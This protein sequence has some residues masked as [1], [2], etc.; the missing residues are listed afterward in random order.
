MSAVNAPTTLADKLQSTIT[1]GLASSYCYIP[2][3]HYNGSWGYNFD[4]VF[5]ASNINLNA[6]SGSTYIKDLAAAAAVAAINARTDILPYTTVKIKRFSDCQSHAAGYAM[7][8]MAAQIGEDHG[9]VV[10]VVGSEYSGPTAGSAEVLGQFEIPYCSSAASSA[11]LSNKNNYPYFFRLIQSTGL[12]EYLALLY[13]SWGVSRI[14][15][16]SQSDDLMS[17]SL[18]K[19]VQQGL[20]HH[21]I[22]VVTIVNLYTALSQQ[23]VNVAKTELQIANARY[24]YISGQ[25]DFVSK[26]YF[27]LA[28]TGMVGP[29]FVY[30]G[31]IPPTQIATS[32]VQLSPDLSSLNKNL[33]QMAHLASGFISF[34]G[35]TQTPKTPWL[36]VFYDNVIALGKFD[37]KTKAANSGLH[38]PFSLLYGYWGIG[39]NF[40]CTMM[41]LLGLDELLKRNPQLS[42]GQLSSRGLSQYLNYTQFLDLG[43]NGL[44]SDPISI[45]SQG[46]LRL[47]YRASYYDGTVKSGSSAL[48]QIAFAE[49][50][51]YAS[52]ITFVKNVSA[53]FFGGSTVPPPDGPPIDIIT[54]FSNNVHSSN[55]QGI[56]VMTISGLAF[57]VCLLAFFIKFRNEK[58]V[59]IA[60]VP[61]C[62][63]LAFGSVLVYVSLPFYL[64]TVTG[65]KCAARVWLALMGYMCMMM[66][67]L[68]KNVRLWIILKSKTRV[69]ANLLTWVNRGVI[70]VGVV[71]QLGLLAY[72]TVSSQSAAQSLVVD[73][74]SFSV[75]TT[76][77]SKTGTQIVATYTGILHLLLVVVA[78][79]LRDVDPIYNESAALMSVFALVAVLVSVVEI[80]PASKNRDL[81]QCVC[82]WLATSLSLVLLF[83]TKVYEVA[84]EGWVER[85]VLKRVVKSSKGG[86][87]Q[88]GIGSMIS[89]GFGGGA[90]GKGGGATVGKSVKASS[91]LSR[92]GSGCSDEEEE[93][94]VGLKFAYIATGTLRAGTMSA[95]DTPTTL[96]DKLQSTITIGLASTYCYI[97]GIHYNRSWAYNFDPVFNAS[98]IDLNGGSG[99]AYIKDLAAAAAVAAINART[100]ILPYTTVRIKRFS[101]CQ[102]QAAG[103]AMAEMAI[104]IGQDHDDVIAVVGSE[105]SG[106]T[107]N[108]AEVLGQFKIP[109]CSSSASTPTLSNKNNYP[110]FFRLIQS[111]GLGEYLA[112]LYKSWGVGRI[113]IIS[114]SDDLMSRSLT[115]DVHQGL[116]AHGIEVVTVINLYTALSKQMVKFARTELKIA[117][118]RYIY[119]SGQSDFVSKIYFSLALTGMAGPQFVYMGNIPPTKIS[120]SLAQLSPRLST[121]NKNLTQLAQLAS[122]FITF[123]GA[124]QNPKTPWLQVFYDNVVALGIFDNKTKSKYGLDSPLSLLYDYW[125]IGGNFDCAMMILLGVD[126]LLKRN[127]QL[128]AGQLS[129]R[130]ISQY[131]NYTQFLDLGYNGLTSDPISLNSQGDLRLPYRASYYDGT[132][133]SGS[134]ALNQIAFAETDFYASNITFVKNVSVVFFGGS[135]VPPPDGPPIDIITPFSNTIQSPNGQGILVMT[136]SGLAFS[137]C[138]LGFFIKFR[139]EKVVKIASVPECIFLIFG[140]FLVY[141]SLLFYLNT[142]TGPKCA[143]R[144]WLALVGYVCMTM[145]I[146]MK[147]VRLWIILKSK[148][149][150]DASL[151]TWVNRGVIAVGVFVQL[152]LLVYWTASS[153]STTLPLVVDDFSFSI[154]T[155]S[156]SETATYLLIAYAGFI[157]LLLVVVAYLLRDVD[158]IFNESA[159]L[160]SMFALVAVLVGVVEI[161]PVSKNRDLI[162]SV[163]VWLATSSSLVLLFGGKVYEVAVEEWVEKMVLKRVA[164][165]SRGGSGQG[166]IGSSGGKK[167]KVGGASVGKGVKATSY[168][169]RDGSGC[170]D[171]EEEGSVG[172]KLGE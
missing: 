86:S 163:C 22:E 9:D 157:H 19:D 30:M 51:F 127:P 101:D 126:E 79:L 47:P 59:K 89:S 21:G 129:S 104:E 74:F 111:T 161:L 81:I 32:M 44:T 143:A 170:Y 128:S 140:S 41:I 42:A 64:N 5:N 110:Y 108:A 131:L 28:L 38:S 156:G 83:G 60:S 99:S 14:T 6:G 151:L 167:G 133:K 20:S 149:K 95:V 33:T 142:V 117:D 3:I 124:T 77:G 134:S 12:G 80:L 23:M 61:E 39:G 153:Q 145:P 54:P 152:G 37:N 132:V 114:Q 160:M 125:G 96:A 91:K 66:P 107:A 16:I 52:N 94:S 115:D 43:Y 135:T 26:I 71:V 122:G 15:I 112:L 29:Q 138:L 49:T 171:E 154:C 8:E 70:A 4:P 1:I 105:Y 2:G 35:A 76:S 121:V 141:V 73:S 113:A 98:N 24:I 72:W 68:M 155:A 7:T 10:A 57:S 40:D 123:D 27:S 92:G 100:D 25:S 82:V 120:T 93:G 56:L 85:M 172:L 48:N 97:P 18:T 109:Y 90:K 53:I 36:Q 34:T 106:N 102:S 46:D 67:I 75:C 118:A 144:V 78:Y 158:P 63:F 45:N 65:P 11:T 166:A 88:S 17:R 137:A 139:N 162:Q 87:G 146:V 55:G 136:I 119:I 148:T 84:V 164:K 169:S 62:I 69:D 13:K 130:G 103:Y 159:A 150:V 58:A 168:L 147:N 31:N 50:D 165:T 116:A